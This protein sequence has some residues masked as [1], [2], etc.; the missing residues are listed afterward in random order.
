[1]E[2]VAPVSKGQ[3]EADDDA[4]VFQL[5]GEWIVESGGGKCVFVDVDF[6]LNSLDQKRADKQLQK[7]RANLLFSVLFVKFA[8]VISK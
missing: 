6:F 7:A 4:D 1:M 3:F 8:S 2:T 5:S